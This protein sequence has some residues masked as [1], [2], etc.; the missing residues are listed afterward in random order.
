MKNLL[1]LIFAF[2]LSWLVFMPVEM[3]VLG[4]IHH[5]WPLIPALG[6]RTL[7]FI[8]LLTNLLVFSHGIGKSLAKLMD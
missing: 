2:I 7:F 4:A 5:H 1:L 3:L 6:Y 8:S